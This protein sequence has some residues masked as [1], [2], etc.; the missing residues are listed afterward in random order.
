MG[1]RDP[2]FKGCTRPAMYWG[3]PVL[4]F[5]CVVGAG[6]LVA[7]WLNLL[8]LFLLVPI[9]FVMRNIAK[10]DDQQFRLLFLRMRFRFS[11]WLQGG[12]RFWRCSAYSPIQFKRR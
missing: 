2:L 10:K 8:L 1:F 6:V 7:L 12:L 11:P 3:I 4:P 9:L 5:G